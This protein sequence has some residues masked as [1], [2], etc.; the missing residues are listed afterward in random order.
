MLFLTSGTAVTGIL[1]N[2]SLQEWSPLVNDSVCLLQQVSCNC[3]GKCSHLLAISLHWFRDWHVPVALL[4]R[5]L[6]CH[7]CALSSWSD[8]PSR[9]SNKLHCSFPEA[10]GLGKDSWESR[11]SLEVENGRWCFAYRWILLHHLNCLISQPHGR[12]VY[13][14][15]HTHAGTLTQKDWSYSR[16]VSYSGE[17]IYS[18]DLFTM[19]LS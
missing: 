10:E 12:T 1:S 13:L 11:G 17:L 3:S 18:S 14:H 19:K 5:T 2:I 15:T 9:R 7:P 16:L 4:H 8:E 6:N